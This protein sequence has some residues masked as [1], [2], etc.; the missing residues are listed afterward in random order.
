MIRP[1]L[2]ERVKVPMCGNRFA[3]VLDHEEQTKRTE[4]IISSPAAISDIR[5][6]EITLWAVTIVGGIARELTVPREYHG[7]IRTP[8]VLR[9]PPRDV[10]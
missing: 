1:N 9:R 2:R 3:A 4:N 10:F 8:R 7:A 6:R 5:Y